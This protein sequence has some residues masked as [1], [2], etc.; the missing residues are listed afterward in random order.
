MKFQISYHLLPTS[1]GSMLVILVFETSR[2]TDSKQ[3][4]TLFANFPETENTKKGSIAF[5][6]LAPTGAPILG[7]LSWETF[8]FGF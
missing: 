5:T 6:N 1:T 2:K 3:P 4:L 8:Y 7:N